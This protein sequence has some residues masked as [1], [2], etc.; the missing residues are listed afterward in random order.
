MAFLFC[1][2]FENLSKRQIVFWLVLLAIVGFRGWFLPESKTRTILQAQSLPAVPS[3]ITVPFRDVIT[4]ENINFFLQIQYYIRRI[5]FVC[6]NHLNID[7][8]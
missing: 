6:L 8:L 3:Q 5:V 2:V 7:S 1:E 4:E